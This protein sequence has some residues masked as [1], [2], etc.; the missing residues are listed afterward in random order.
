MIKQKR[1]DEGVMEN[2]VVDYTHKEDAVGNFNQFGA[3]MIGK[4]FTTKV[5]EQI[6][7]S[8]LYLWDNIQCQHF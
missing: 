1:V 3:P 6:V 7:F 8:R 4:Q 5:M 2:K